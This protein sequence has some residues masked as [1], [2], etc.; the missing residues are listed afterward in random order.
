MGVGATI[1]LRM[2]DCFLKVVQHA[3]RALTKAEVNYSQPDREGLAVIH[4]ITKF[5]RKIYGRKFTLQTDHA[6]L[7]RIFG[8]RTGIPVYTANRLQRWALT[9]LLYDFKIE[10][11]P[12][13]KFG[14]ADI[15]SRLIASAR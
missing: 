12:T 13:D 1:S 2:S 5:H 8:S 6:P 10:Y 3:A 14:N 4:A 9:L 11:V 7:I 15:L